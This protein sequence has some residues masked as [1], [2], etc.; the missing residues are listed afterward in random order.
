[1]LAGFS[2]SCIIV[3]AGSG[4]RFGG[5]KLWLDIAGVPVIV[6][7]LRAFDQPWCDQ[8][9]V[10]THPDLLASHQQRLA[11]FFPADRL[12]FIAGGAERW[13]SSWLGIQH[14]TGDLVAI[15]DAARPFIKP[16]QIK[17]AFLAASKSGAALVAAPATDSIKIADASGEITGSIDR[18]LVFLAQTPQ[19]FR[20][21]LITRAYQTALSQGYQ[22]MTDDVELVTHFLQQPVSVIAS[23]SQNMKI[24]YPS[25]RLIAETIAKNL[26]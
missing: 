23:T 6:R 5:D 22:Q 12:Q 26:D 3:A 25:D 11:S 8:I 7:T 1:M 13:Q 20:R 4:Q 16:L 14:A 15:H 2:T 10:V 18:K 17:Q 24:T 21:E 19:V 9:I